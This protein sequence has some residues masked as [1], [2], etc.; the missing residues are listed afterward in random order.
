[1]EHDAQLMDKVRK[2][3]PGYPDFV[4]VQADAFVMEE[5]RTLVTDLG[6]LSD[7]ERSI[8][9]FAKAQ[10]FV[11]GYVAAIDNEYDPRRTAVVPEAMSNP[12]WPETTDLIVK[13]LPETDVPELPE[14]PKVPWPGAR[15]DRMDEPDAKAAALPKDE[16]EKDGSSTDEV[17]L[18]FYA[19]FGLPMPL[20]DFPDEEARAPYMLR[21]FTLARMSSFLTSQDADRRWRSLFI[22]HTG[23]GFALGFE[24]GLDDVASGVAD[25]L[26]AQE[27]P[28]GFAR[29]Q[30]QSELAHASACVATAMATA[31][32]LPRICAA[33][34]LLPEWDAAALDGDATFRGA[35]GDGW[36][37]DELLR[38]DWLAEMWDEGT[39]A[40]G[41]VGRLMRDV[42]DATEG[43]AL[44]RHVR[45]SGRN[46]VSDGELC[47]LCM[48]YAAQHVAG[49]CDQSFGDLGRLPEP[50]DME[51]AVR[52]TCWDIADECH[53]NDDIVHAM[54]TGVI[55]KEQADLVR[56][57]AYRIMEGFAAQRFLMDDAWV[58]E[59]LREKA[60]EGARGGNWVAS[61]IA[62]AHGVVRADET[63][64][65]VGDEMRERYEELVAVRDARQ[66]EP[67]QEIR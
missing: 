24:Y 4:Y 28:E 1:M 16:E 38:A 42:A 20:P 47:E 7:E 2:Y 10:G 3:R 51:L 5:E 12:E 14:K 22:P 46:E 65:A 9:L 21:P 17:P 18:S 23:Y 66:D 62:Y 48:V 27:D 67:V 8:V 63:G 57:V 61:G 59:R 32:S 31:C 34:G 26:S 56:G 30:A 43:F 39:A 50:E 60:L 53:V 15:P 29:R 37:D 44:D 35:F 49:F 25:R 13:R 19:D 6:P 40:L 41:T 55:A 36:D 33:L 64:M 11:E 54:E 58:W 45:L 52:T